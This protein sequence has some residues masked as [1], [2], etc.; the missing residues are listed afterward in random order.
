MD[1]LVLENFV[2]H[3]D[4]QPHV[5]AEDIERYKSQFELD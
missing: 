2:L 3:R 5:S 4:Q 1:V